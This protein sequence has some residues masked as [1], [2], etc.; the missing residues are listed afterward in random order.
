MPNLTQFSFDNHRVVGD[1]KYRVLPVMSGKPKV[2]GIPRHDWVLDSPQYLLEKNLLIG[3]L[4]PK[5]R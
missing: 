3:S 1:P 4:P 5:N 2:S